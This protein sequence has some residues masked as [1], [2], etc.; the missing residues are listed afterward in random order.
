[1]SGY[2]TRS[3]YDYECTIRDDKIKAEADVY[4]CKKPISM[5]MNNP[6]GHIDKHYLGRNPGKKVSEQKFDRVFVMRS[7]K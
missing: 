4:T 6:E 7:T 3:Q 5:T 1:M 2:L